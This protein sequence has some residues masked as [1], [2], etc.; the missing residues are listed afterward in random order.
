MLVWLS[1]I[2]HFCTV[3]FRLLL[4]ASDS[5]VLTLRPGELLSVVS[6]VFVVPVLVFWVGLEKSE[7]LNFG[8][9]KYFLQ[10]RILSTAGAA[11]RFTKQTSEIL[12]I[13]E[14]SGFLHC[15]EYSSAAQ[16]IEAWRQHSNCWWM[17]ACEVGD[18]YHFPA[19]LLLVAK[20]IQPALTRVRHLLLQCCTILLLDQGIFGS[21]STRRHEVSVNVV[22]Y[23]FP[24]IQK[25][26]T[27]VIHYNPRRHVC[28]WTRNCL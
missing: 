8:C 21:T 26:W 16:R 10:R 28:C 24:C 12:F 2:V 7:W 15:R 18:S 22:W 27:S 20:L 3:C 23:I 5:L 19:K 11:P 4:P 14:N 17:N 1:K 13:A 9:E 25:E 6:H